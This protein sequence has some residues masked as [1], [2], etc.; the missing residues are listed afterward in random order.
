MSKR[1]VAVACVFTIVLISWM[2]RVAYP[3]N[4]QT[5]YNIDNSLCT[6]SLANSPNCGGCTTGNVPDP[7]FNPCP[8]GRVCASIQCSSNPM[9]KAFVCQYVSTPVSNPCIQSS[10]IVNVNCS[11]CQFWFTSSP[12]PSVNGNCGTGKIRN[13]S[14]LTQG[15]VYPVTAAYI[16]F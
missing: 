4:N 14:S 6:G 9:N 8:G 5:S 15:T 1:I 16:C 7:R 2:T 10:S 3:Q 11:K 12:C 13:C